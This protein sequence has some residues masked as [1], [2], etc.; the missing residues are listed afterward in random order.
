MRF[1]PA[2]A[3]LVT[4][5]ALY[6]SRGVLDQFLTDE[7]PVRVALLPPWQALGAFVGLAALGLLWLDRMTLP[8]GTS[9]ALGP[10][11]GPLVLPAL[12]LSVLLLPYAPYIADALPVLQILAGPLATVIWVAVIAQFAWVLWQTPLWPHRRMQRWD[13]RQ[14]AWAVGLATALVSGGAAMRFTGTPLFPAGDEPHYLVMAQ[15]I[16]R[17]GDLKIENNHTRRDYAEYFRRD[18]DPHYLTRGSDGEIYSIHPVGMPVLIAPIYAV[19]GYRGVVLAF[20]LM[21]AL[22]A[23]LMWQ[24][25]ARVSGAI[26]ASTFAWAAVVLTTPFLYNSFAVYPEIPAALAVIVAFALLT[27]PGTSPG[28]TGRWA[29]VGVAAG[30]LPWLS[31]KY[32]PMS[33]MLIALGLARI[34]WPTGSRISDVFGV[35]TSGSRRFRALIPAGALL[36][37]YGLSLLAWFTFFYVIWGTPRPQAP[38]GALVQTRPFNLVF[39]APGLLFDQEYGL[40]PYAPVY[41][42]VASGL[43]VM[44]R[45]GNELRRLAFEVSLT[46]AALLA[47]VGAFRIW[48][49]GSA[50]PGRPLTSGLLLLALPIAVAFTAFPAASA[51]R[52]AA[53]LLLWLSIGITGILFVVQE[54]FLIS[55]ARDGTSSLLEYL[56]PRW[57]AWSLAPSFIY[58]EAPT[59]WVYAL[60]WLALAGLAGLTLRRMTTTSPGVAS[61]GAIGVCAASLLAAA[62]VVPL[63]PTD[64][65]WPGVDLEAR[66]RLPVLDRFDSVTR[67]VAVEYAPMRVLEASTATTHTAL[68]VE[69]GT[70]SDPQP[71]RVLHN[72]RFS[73]P[74]GE[75]AVEVE[76]IG[77]RTGETLGLQ[78]GRT[79]DAWRTW[80][81]NPEPGGQWTAAFTAPMDMSFVGL[82]GTPEL[83]QVIGRIAVIPRS[84]VDATR[85]PRLPT[86]LGA[87]D[88]GDASLFYHDENVFP[89]ERGFWV[90]GGHR[91]AQVSVHRSDMEGPLRLRV[92]SGVI[93]NRLEVSMSGWSTTVAL[94]PQSPEQIEIPATGR[95]SLVTLTF[96]A[97][98]GFVPMEIDGASRD[99]R[100]LGAWVEVVR[101]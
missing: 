19:G 89:E 37:P 73:L 39:G 11:L 77:S 5:L 6:V 70:R 16:W 84:V 68:V 28:S 75:Y 72:G 10:S 27:H 26:G 79:G 3:V 44:W 13:V 51:R 43:W 97:A 96:S 86:V 91:R 22:A 30:A 15:S 45:A 57:P 81:V 93:A 65:P 74:A 61:A 23:A 2:L 38:Y 55:N 101:E 18:L 62:L 17:D 42:L 52:A 71:I 99:A 8:R 82:R 25:M 36:L 12:G 40:L 66:A 1:A 100:R 50:S 80:R 9:A 24:T 63:L 95:R 4:G 58:H 56:S 32:A 46:F 20:V 47:T 7:G 21:A 76:W 54:G 41:I 33:A 87:S 69:P 49:G 34:A 67:P 83:E 85:R 90:R 31:T 59:A 35:W 29:A 94:R 88:S 14:L 92:H 48:W 78:I 60:V 64:P 53:H 98:D